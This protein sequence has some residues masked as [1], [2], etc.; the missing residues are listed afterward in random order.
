MHPNKLV[1]KKEDIRGTF[2]QNERFA[3]KYFTYV[4]IFENPVAQDSFITLLPMTDTVQDLY[5]N[6]QNA[7]CYSLLIQLCIGVLDQNKRHITSV[8]PK[9][10]RGHVT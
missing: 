10:E 2:L 8:N 3:H 5:S 7:G 6:L 4:H 9:M 1:W